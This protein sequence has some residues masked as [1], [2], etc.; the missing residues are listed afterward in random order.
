MKTKSHVYGAPSQHFQPRAELRRTAMRADNDAGSSIAL[1]AL[2]A[3]PPTRYRAL[4]P[5]RPGL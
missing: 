3:R 5:P 1:H 4:T 2:R